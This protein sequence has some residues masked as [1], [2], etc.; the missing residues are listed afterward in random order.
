MAA[1]P[2]LNRGPRRLRIARA[3]PVLAAG[4]LLA[5]PAHA[6]GAANLG[7]FYAGLAQ[8][9]Y[10]PESLLLIV[11][12]GLWI[13]QAPGDRK[14]PML[15]A[16]AGAVLAGAALAFAGVA[17]PG[18]A[19]SVRGGALLVGGLVALR[20]V[21]PLAPVAL[22]A[23]LLGAGQ[24]HV[25]S[26]ADRQEVARPILYALGL[27]LAPLLVASWFILLAERYEARWLQVGFRVAGSWI[28][29][30]ALLVATLSLA[31][32]AG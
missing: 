1:A 13:G 20:C 28:A 6:H 32:P 31:K 5:G 24:G 17:V 25:G 7:D 22:L 3:L 10:H 30:I 27:G 16:F 2:G 18:M 9:L 12:F 4:S 14:L 11:A 26:F 29:T 8:P 21:P 19:W 23:L 15:L